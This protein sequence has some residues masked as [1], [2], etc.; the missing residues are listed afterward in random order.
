MFG[1]YK[2]HSNKPPVTTKRQQNFSFAWR[3]NLM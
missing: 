1:I 3:F 2:L